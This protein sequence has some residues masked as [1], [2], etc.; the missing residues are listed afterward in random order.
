MPDNA[1]FCSACGN[2]L[3]AVAAAPTASAPQAERFVTIKREG[4]F[5]TEPMS[6]MIDGGEYAIL[7]MGE[8]KSFPI[9]SFQSQEL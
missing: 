7:R 9:P 4:A 6:V 1:G 3:G 2:P 8:T 5:G